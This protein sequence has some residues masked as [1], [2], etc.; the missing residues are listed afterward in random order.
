MLGTSYRHNF[1]QDGFALDSNVA[2]HSLSRGETL[3]KIR[4]GRT[5]DAQWARARMLKQKVGEKK[6]KRPFPF[7]IMTI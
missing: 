2:Y 5:V 3:P 4:G 1:L 6:S 7:L